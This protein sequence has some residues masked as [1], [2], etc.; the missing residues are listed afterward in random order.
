MMIA[1][2][3]VH[4]ANALACGQSSWTGADLAQVEATARQM[5]LSAN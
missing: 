5:H 1:D 3:L 4:L 2:E